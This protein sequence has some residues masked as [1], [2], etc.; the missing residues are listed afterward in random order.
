MCHV[1]VL[2]PVRL[3]LLAG[4][5]GIYSGFL[6]AAS[7]LRYLFLTVAVLLLVSAG[8]TGLRSAVALYLFV[9]LLAGMCGCQEVDHIPD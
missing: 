5:C 9:S 1:P 7:S 2:L 3:G 4:T 6:R 8:W